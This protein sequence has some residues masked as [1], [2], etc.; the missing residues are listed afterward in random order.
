MLEKLFCRPE[1]AE[2]S[3]S[4]KERAFLENNYLSQE[5]LIDPEVSVV[6][7]EVQAKLSEAYPD[8]FISAVVVGG[9]SQR[10]LPIEVCTR[11][12]SFI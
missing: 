12:Q 5:Y 8:T 6:F 2:F 11:S 3:L 7:S 9:V 10:E 1:K 4:D